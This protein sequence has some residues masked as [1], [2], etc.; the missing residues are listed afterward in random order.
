MHYFNSL[1]I[2]RLSY[3]SILFLNF[4]LLWSN[5][6]STL[7]FVLLSLSSSFLFFLW[8]I[9]EDLRQIWGLKRVY[10]YFY[11]SLDLEVLFRDS[12]SCRLILFNLRDLKISFRFFDSTSSTTHLPLSSK[13]PN[14][15]T[16]KGSSYSSSSNARPIISS[17]K[18]LV[19]LVSILSWTPQRMVRNLN[20]LDLLTEFRRS[21]SESIWAS[22]LE[23]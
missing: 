7:S 12:I 20:K 3:L 16:I 13:V 4:S 6:F 22:V 18:Q 10:F 23:S 8:M 9:L 14:F 15:I 19:L 17:S 21:G 2:L 11:L 1:S 5:R